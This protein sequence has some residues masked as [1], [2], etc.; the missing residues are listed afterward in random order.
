MEAIRTV[1]SSNPIPT[2]SLDVEM[3]IDAPEVEEVAF[4]LVTN[5]KRKGKAKASSPS[6]T[7]SRNK[8]PLVSRA[9][10]AP[11]TVTT[12]AASKP[13]S[14]RS[15]L[16]VAAATTSKPAQ[17]QNR[18]PLVLL[19]SKPK[20]KAKSFSQAVKANMSG[21]KFAPAS[22]HEDFLRLLQLKETFPDLP[23]A[24]IISMHQ[25]GLGVARASQGGPSRPAVSR[26]LKMTTQGLTRH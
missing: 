24:T 11:K 22:S 13:A 2:P 20:P 7:N 23:Q 26:T 16:A 1:Y 25:V 10:P 12:S 9:P 14:T 19:A 18:P 6:L 5:K 15:P 4:T 3:N 21:P 8:I 17:P